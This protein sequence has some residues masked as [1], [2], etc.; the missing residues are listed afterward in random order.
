MAGSQGM[1]PAVWRFFLC[2]VCLYPQAAGMDCRCIICAG[3]PCSSQTMTW[4]FLHAGI[5]LLD[6]PQEVL[7]AIFSH[8]KAH[9]WAQG[10]AQSCRL[11]SRMV[12]SR[13]ALHVPVPVRTSAAPVTLEV[14]HLP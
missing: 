7:H 2:A 5:N 14:L 4:P 13:V 11:L 3:D 10:P 9:E 1:H 6:L 8:F 12:L